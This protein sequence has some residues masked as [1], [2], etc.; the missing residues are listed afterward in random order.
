LTGKHGDFRRH[1]RAPAYDSRESVRDRLSAH[2]TLVDAGGFYGNCGSVPV[3]SGEPA[4]A[5]VRARQTFSYLSN[6]RVLFDSENL[7]EKPKG[8]T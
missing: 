2:R 8:K 5:A 3:A 7:L 1:F 4:C 6:K